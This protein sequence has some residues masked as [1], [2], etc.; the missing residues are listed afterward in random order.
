MASNAASSADACLLRAVPREGV[1][2]RVRFL[3]DEITGEIHS[4][5]PALDPRVFTVFFS[6]LSEAFAVDAIS[7]VEGVPADRFRMWFEGAD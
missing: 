5:L 6:L 1:E 7:E 2:T 4:T 3:G